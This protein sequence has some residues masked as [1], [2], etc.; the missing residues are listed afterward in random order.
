[1]LKEVFGEKRR[2]GKKEKTSTME[3]ENN[4]TNALTYETP[5]KYEREILELKYTSQVSV[6]HSGKAT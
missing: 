3:T 1:M 5:T 2:P 4:R 6:I